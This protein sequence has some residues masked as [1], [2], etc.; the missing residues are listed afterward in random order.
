[1]LVGDPSSG[2]SF[3]CTVTDIANIIETDIGD[4]YVTLTTTQTISGV[5]TF[6]NNLTLT[7]V[8]NASVDT[9]KF[10]VLS[11]LNVV[12]FRTGSEVLSDI[13]AQGTITLTTTGTS[14]AAT[15]SSN[16]LNIP[17]YQGA[18]TLTTTGTSGAATLVGNTLN[19]PNY[20]PDLSGYV[21]TSRTITINGVSQ[22]LSA[23][24][25][26]NVG[27]VT[28]VAATAGTGISISGSPI[29]SSGTL[30]ITNTAPDQVVALTAGTGISISGTYP[31]FTITNISP[32]LGG[33]VT[34]VALSAPTGFS[35]TGSPVTTSG[36]LGL[37]FATG[38][39]LPTTAS[40]VNWDA[41]YNDKINS[42]SVSGTTTK[43]LTL[44]QQDGGTLSTSW[45]DDNT[46]AVTSVFGRTG[47]VVATEGDYSLTQLSDVTI[48]TP[49][50]GQVLKYNGTTWINDTDANTGT[51]T[52]VA[53]SVPTGL[54]VSGSPI[55]S[56]G[57]LAVTFAS[58]YSISTTASQ[59]NWDTAYTNRITSLT[60]TGSSGAATLI[61]N[62]LNIPNYTLSGLGG[63]PTT[64]TLTINGTALDLSVDRSWSVG[65]VTSV[66]ATAGTG[67]SISG[68]PITS[69]GTL[70]ITN[71]APDQVVA[72]T[73]GT[74]I[75]TSGTY[76]NF[77]ITNSAPDQTVSLTAG[78]NITITG[79][80]PN[81]TIAAS[82]GGGTGTVTS[83]GLS[84]TTSGI[85]IGSTPITTSGT[86][87]L[88]IATASG[89]QQGL[90]SS[91][92]W[93]TFNNK[94]NALTNPVTGTGTTNYIPKFTSSTAVGDSRFFDD[95]T[96][97]FLGNG[98]VNASPSTAI[99]SGTGGSGTNIAG[100]EF[101]IRGGAGT[102]TG[103]GGPITFYTSAAGTTGSAVN[104]ATERM[105]I[106]NAGNVGINTTSP[107][108]NL[109]VST[110]GNTQIN[111]TAGS[112]ALSRLIFGTTSG[113][114]RGFID[115][116]NTSSVRA[117]IFRTNESERMRITSGGNIGIGTTTIGS[118]L[119]VNGNAAIGYS[120]ST[121]APTNGLQVAGNVGVGVSPSAWSSAYSAL[122]LNA[123]ASLAGTSTGVLRLMNNLFINS[124]GEDRY[125][126][127]AA[128]TAYLQSAG[129]HVFFTAAS[130]T[131]GGLASTTQ[132]M[133]INNSGNVGIA[134]N[135]VGSTLQ[136]NGNAAIGYSASTAA[137]TNGLAVSGNVAIGTNSSTVP[138]LVSSTASHV[139]TIT[140]NNT[141]GTQIYLVNTSTGGDIFRI[142]STGQSNTEGAGHLLIAP[143]TGA[144]RFI[145]QGSGN[146]GIN[147]TT[148]GS[149]LQVNGNAA[150]GYSAS[151]AAPTNGLAVSGNVGIGVTD[152]DIFARG[153]ARMVGIGAS[154][155]SDNLALALNA[156][157]TGG[158]GA[159]IYMGQGGTRH[160]TISS[161]VTET[162]LGTSSSTPLKFTTNDIERMRIT[163]GGNVGIG[164]TSPSGQL[165]LNGSANLL[166]TNTANTS[167]F[168]IGLL[169]GT[170]DATAYIYQRANS[171]MIFATNN[172]ERMRITSGGNLGLGVTPSAWVAG[173]GRT[174]AQIGVT[175]VSTN[176]GNDAFFGANY[177]DDGT[178]NKYINSDFSL[179]YGQQSGEHRWYSAPSGTAGNNITFTQA[180]TLN[181]SGN[182]GIG[183]T[184]IGSRLQVNGNAAIGYSAS[185]AAPTNGLQ[186]AG[187]TRIGTTTANDFFCVNAGT[188][189]S[190]FAVNIEVVSNF[191]FGST[192]GRRTMSIR[193]SGANDNG[194]QFGYDATDNTG[195]I[196]GAATLNGTG[197][198]FYTFNGSTWGNRM[199]VTKDGQLNL[200]TGSNVSAIAQTGYSLTGSNASSLLDLAGTWN[201]TGNPTAI[202]LNITNTASGATADLMEL[203]V[204]GTSQFTVDKSGNTIMTGSVKTGAPTGGTAAT[205]KL[206][207]KIS[208][209]MA[210]DDS[211]YLEVEVG[212]TTYYVALCFPA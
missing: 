160:F 153:D 140:S 161:N 15:F 10:L 17:Q 68:S 66:A 115:Y 49:T 123:T 84:S 206:G 132:R 119:Q 150:I 103:V 53:L 50:N 133:V 165:H 187:S 40:Q 74:G 172:S 109:D 55:T 102:G 108:G 52:S 30:T 145:M 60:T 184:T 125:I 159:Q 200:L 210:F 111:I 178:N 36:T 195:I 113:N 152:P 110:S 180:M 144:G 139:Q 104:A 21:P 44:T 87:T 204:G 3:K 149:R 121:A 56:S 181:A 29:T 128:A 129:Q 137:P 194:L 48:T 86:I 126:T 35:V 182:L 32:S 37:T 51:V 166:M 105:R 12:T 39:S 135:T 146:I 190:T 25:T 136:V 90:L 63:V 199:R 130:G 120:A 100:A 197:I 142:F 192:N 98:D 42:V 9:D 20:A 163:S 2:Y 155:A 13:G 179:I 26:Y 134:T 65:T 82:G 170:S 168:E 76:P 7:S 201:T 34:S 41:A 106:N 43:T 157:G 183:T 169:G 173:A 198:D 162:T 156:G 73:A 185:T 138:L 97:T 112:T 77:T 14:G 79:T 174:A 203:Q 64:R 101:R 171:A 38:Y 23:N 94:Q 46:D 61:S 85:T 196:A 57:T 122:Q 188:L 208:N 58:G 96:I 88:D 202:K 69:S 19:I 209:T 164:T 211:G 167:G 83:V 5:K 176:S 8:T 71:T 191:A 93:T 59:T 189:A 6:S 177:Y 148:V 78:S 141:G 67:I 72:L 22:D 131:A 54:S 99:L 193:N 91:T 1:M 24:R 70:T 33:T 4:A 45:T 16:T 89:S 18:L 127:T 158:R 47:A 95:G 27:T 116:D 117:M 205:W 11:A 124:S 143:I 81:F 114:S 92:D 151:T 147:T 212:G 75:S 186:V 107:L 154:G 175:S 80:Y 118:T 62:T 207:S 28:S 31:N